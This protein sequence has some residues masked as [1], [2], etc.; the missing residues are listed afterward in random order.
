MRFI[1]LAGIVMLTG[2]A[3]TAQRARYQSTVTVYVTDAVGYPIEAKVI[4]KDKNG[5]EYGAFIADGDSGTYRAIEI[6]HDRD[7]VLTVRSPQFIDGQRILDIQANEYWVQ[8]GLEVGYLGRRDTVDITGRITFAGGSSGQR[9]LRVASIYTPDIRD[10][11]IDRDGKFLI[12]GV[13]PGFGSTAVMSI[14]DG[15]SLCYVG[16]LKRE[17]FSNVTVKIEQP[18]R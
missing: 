12:S 13:T 8:V 5:K 3:I 11:R 6:P 16:T 14:M 1:F 2:T 15:E 9:W 4:L 7:Y 18:C 10:A 17:T